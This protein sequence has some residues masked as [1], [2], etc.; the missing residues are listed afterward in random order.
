MH[1]RY[2]MTEKIELITL[3]LSAQRIANELSVR[4]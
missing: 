1:L 4:A 3:R 2:S